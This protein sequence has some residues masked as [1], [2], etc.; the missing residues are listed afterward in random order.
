[1]NLADRFPQA[2]QDVIA[3]V[4][5]VDTRDLDRPTPCTDFD[6]RSLV[7]HFVGTTAALTRVARRQ[8]L[9][10]ADPYGSAKDPVAGDWQSELSG[11]LQQLGV[12]WSDLDAWAGTVDMGGG[13]MPATMIA[14]MSLAEMLLHGWDLARATGQ[15]LTVPREVGAEL[16]RSI[17]ET[18]ELGRSMGAYGDA[19]AVPDDAPQF[20]RALGASGRDPRWPES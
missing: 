6:L 13:A 4:K 5:G 11:N 12:A 3:V 1:M 9:D 14:E 8:P 19:I 18:A 10:A 16:L 17:E 7:N 2:A 15:E 20:A